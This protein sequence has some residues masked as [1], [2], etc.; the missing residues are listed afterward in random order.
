MITGGRRPGG[1]GV[2][3]HHLAV[4]EH[5]GAAELDL[6]RAR[7]ARGRRARRACR[8]RRG[9][10]T[11]C[12]RVS[13]HFGQIIAGSFSTRLRSITNDADSEPIT[14]AAR[15][16]TK[17]SQCEARI[18][19]TSS[20]LAQVLGLLVVAALQAAQVDDAL[21]RRRGARRRRRTA[22]PRGRARRTRRPTRPPSSA[23]GSRRRRCPRR[24]AGSVSGFRTSPSTISASAGSFAFARGRRGPGSGRD[25]RRG[26]VRAAGSRRR[27]R[28]IR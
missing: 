4:G 16:W 8:R 6:R 13:I 28:S 12:V 5:V 3:D 14:I 27:S 17:S 18:R 9:S 2:A 19:A 24:A 22:R 23:R 10:T 21:R 1:L 20:R 11:G 15:T 25:G 7:R 26:A